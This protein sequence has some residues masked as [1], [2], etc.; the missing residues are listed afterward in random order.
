VKPVLLVAG[1]LALGAAGIAGAAWWQQRLRPIGAGGSAAPAP[2][3]GAFDYPVV[4]P[5]AGA[6]A[7]DWKAGHL[8]GWKW[9]VQHIGDGTVARDDRELAGFCPPDADRTA[10]FLAGYHAARER[11]DAL[12]ASEGLKDARAEVLRQRRMRP[13]LNDLQVVA[14]PP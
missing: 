7:A 10:A 3:A 1:Y 9:C 11:F 5:R 6:D 14:P 4:V 12:V 2:A 8:D 13:R